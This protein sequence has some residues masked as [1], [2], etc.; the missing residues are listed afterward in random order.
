MTDAI[1][2]GAPYEGEVD[3][4][5]CDR[6]PIHILG[7]VQSYGALIAVSSDWMIQHVSENIVSFLGTEA[8]E[9]VGTPLDTV[10]P[11]AAMSRIRAKVLDGRES[12]NR[13]FGIRLLDPAT[14][15]DVSIHRS[16]RHLVIEFE[17][18]THSTRD[19]DSLSD[20]YPLIQRIRAAGSLTQVTAE[21]ARAV[22]L[23]SGFDSVMVYQFQADDS[24]SVVAED[25]RGDLPSYLGL[26]FPASDIPV[27]AR[28]LYKRSLLRLIADVNDEGAAIYPQVSPEGKPLDLSLSVT[29]AVSPIHIEYLRNMGVEAS[30]SVSIM[31]NGELWGLFACHHRSPRHVEFERRTAIELFAHLFS[32]ELTHLEEQQRSRAQGEMANLQ[33]RLMALMADGDD[34]SESLLK[35]SG[36]LREVIPHDGMVLYTDG[37]FHGI[38]ST[39]TAEEFKGLARFLNT[40]AASGVFSTDCIGNQYAPAADCVDRF[41]GLLAIPISR[42]PRDYLVLFRREIATAVT[43]AGNPTK[44]VTP[45]PNG[46]RL[47]PRKSFEAW[48]EIVA[49]HC[50]P[51]NQH[52]RHSAELL[53]VLLL[54]IFL[55]ITDATAD[56][57]KKAQER[58]ELLISELNHRVRNILNLMRGL[59]KQ[60]V[61]ERDTIGEFTTRLDG[62]IQSLARAHDQLTDDE[63]DYASLLDLID[64]E[65]AAY[66][67]RDSARIEILGTDVQISPK[68][69]TNLALVVHEL[70]TNSVKYGSLSSDNGRLIIALGQDSAGALTID[71][72]E[73]G[74]PPVTP[75][76]RRGFGSSIIE[77]F[78]PFELQ[79]EAD[80]QYKMTGVEAR[81]V[82]PA[83]HVQFVAKETKKDESADVPS[84]PIALQ[85]VSLVLEDTMIIAMDAADI[86]T[87]MG[88]QDVR[89]ASNVA[90]ALREI[91]ANTIELAVL[92]VN[93]GSEQSL[94]VAE[95]LAEL[96]VPFVVAT[97]YGDRDDL[98]GLYPPCPFVRKPFSNETL[99]AA[100]STAISHSKK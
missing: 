41:A 78:V 30:M 25:R 61:Q 42:R 55:K 75:P 97:G 99:E 14:L 64:L 39:P 96:G 60:S 91:E 17:P 33:T 48:R 15:Y 16:G 9:L 27:Q 3:L 76:K 44:P 29:R 93:L 37:D 71:W 52:S 43:W 4:T 6:E 84:G 72:R 24:G 53:R 59:V 86:L 66:V 85:G 21:A 40:T 79:G 65:L 22:R 35:V 57:R 50:T 90:D 2:S 58:Q 56:E 34:L 68:A 88:A 54:E 31:R 94:P 63:W 26:R 46:L 95:K 20:V 62:R 92:D 77:R 1:A 5:T 69:F 28:A 10:L 36:D 49:G 13:L 83:S 23:L 45:G 12:V 87:E 47:T 38:G 51:W 70:V 18:K 8:T 74:G 32:Y 98:T 81:F 82:I 11:A 67:G 19:D 7:R 80:I 100:I 73:R 89:I